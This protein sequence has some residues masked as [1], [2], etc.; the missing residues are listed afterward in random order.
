MQKTQTN[1]NTRKGKEE[2]Q[3]K[4]SREEKERNGRDLV[5][6]LQVAPSGNPSKG[7]KEVKEGLE[8]GRKER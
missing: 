1:L 4:E 6:S 7:L 5:I 3:R 2:K 8:G